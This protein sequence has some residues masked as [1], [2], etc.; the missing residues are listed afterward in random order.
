MEGDWYYVLNGGFEGPETASRLLELLDV[1][2]VNQQTPIW[3]Q[4]ASD[5]EPLQAALGLSAGQPPPIPE[6]ASAK[7]PETTA[8]EASPALV[9]SPIFNPAPSVRSISVHPW[10]RLF[11][12]LLDTLIAGSAV[13]FCIGFVLTKADPAA[14]EKFIHF[15][16]SPVGILVNSPVTFF[17]AIVP[18][19]LLI[20]LT[21]SSVGK[22]I[23]GIR[24][25][26]ADGQTIGFRTAFR[27]ELLIWVRGLGLGLPIIYLFSL[28]AAY[29]RLKDTRTT[30][31]DGRLALHPIFR[32]NSAL[33]IVAN[34][35]GSML[36]LATIGVLRALGGA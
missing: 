34:V 19:A 9:T 23:F 6:A 10:R 13:F 2:R 33:Q 1:G 29:R 32:P 8:R 22:L 17:F 5:W 11:A 35:I 14:Q 31:W 3:R 28:W 24:V 18:N 36:L 21:G 26:D 12:R 4:G 25:A 7:A 27:R 30:M 15:L 20:G 16:N